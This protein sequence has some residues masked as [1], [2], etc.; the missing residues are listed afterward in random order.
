MKRWWILGALASGAVVSVSTFAGCGQDESFA[1]VPDG[2]A[3]EGGTP[4]TG[5]PPGGDSGPTPMCSDSTG[6]PQRLLVS[7]N[8]AAASELAAFNLQTRMVDGRLTYPSKLGATWSMNDAPYLLEQSIDVVAK[9]D[10]KEPWKTVGSWNVGDMTDA[11]Y[12]NPLA[13][14][15]PS[16]AKG[17]VVKARRNTI[18]VVDTTK[19]GSAPTAI[20]LSGLLQ[21]DDHDGKVEPTSAVWVPKKKRIY[22]LLGNIDLTR[23]AS[24][25]FTALCAPTHP[26]IVAIDPDTDQ[27]APLSGT[28]PGGSILLQGYS[29]VYGTPLFYDDAL[30]RLIVLEAGCNMDS[31]DGGAGPIARRRIEAVSLAT[32]QVTTL[33]SLDN[34]DFPYALLYVDAARALVGFVD[35]ITFEPKAFMWDPSSNSLGAAL[36]VPLQYAAHDGKGNAVGAY[37]TTVDGGPGFAIA[38]VPFTDA[39]TIDAVTVLGE[40]PFADN[41]S[42][43][44][45]LS[46]AEVWPR[47]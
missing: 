39:G 46:G 14:V 47:P 40:N 32:G 38:S 18:S 7:V 17:Y 15:V 31:G 21:T 5:Q 24:D 23:V 12:T 27:L 25:G 3:V 6:A 11:G 41:D 8:H 30:D 45:F 33:L 19:S 1:P 22:A 2:G 37:A 29:P 42:T 43:K 26:A 13:I 9:L 35:Q 16:C 34:A 10:A 28:G 20:D 44:S 4:P 36:P